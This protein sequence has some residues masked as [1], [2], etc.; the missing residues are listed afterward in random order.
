MNLNFGIYFCLQG[1]IHSTLVA[2]LTKIHTTKIFSVHTVNIEIKEKSSFAENALTEPVPEKSDQ[3]PEI[4]NR[5]MSWYI[6]RWSLLYN[7]ELHIILL[8][9]CY[10]DDSSNLLM[11]FNKHVPT[12]THVHTYILFIESA[13]ENVYKVYF[14]VRYTP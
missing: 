1:Q 11:F 14:F 8:I 3:A 10:E 4:R 7:V 5:N 12:S 2:N 6:N 13:P 9:T